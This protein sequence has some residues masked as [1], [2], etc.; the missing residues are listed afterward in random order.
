MAMQ[1][2]EILPAD[3]QLEKLAGGFVFTEGPVWHPG[4]RCLY[5]SDIPASVTRRR[6]SDGRIEV[7]QSPNGKANGMALDRDGKLLICRHGERRIV[8]RVADSAYEAVAERYNG[9]RFNSPNDIVVKS[10]GS[11]YF[12]DPP[13]GLTREFGEPGEQELPYQGVFR[14]DAARQTVAL[15]TDGFFRPNGLAFSPDESLLYINDSERE[16]VK[17]FDVASDGSLRNERMFAEVHGEEPGCPDGMKVDSLGNVYVTGPGG[18]WIFDPSGQKLGAIAVPEVA[19]NLAF[20][21]ADKK[22]LFITA[23]TSLYRIRVNVPGV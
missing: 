6:T 5:F 3:A 20:G 22:T 18:I 19:A 8:K 1:F 11:L 4:E 15:L 16:F 12:T 13:Y 9:K 21:D 2:R 17:V 10:D 7:V 23:S 14:M